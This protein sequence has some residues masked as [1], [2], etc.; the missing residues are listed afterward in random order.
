MKSYALMLERYDKAMRVMWGL[1]DPPIG[2]ANRLTVYIV[3]NIDVVRRLLGSSGRAAGFYTGRAEG[4]VAVVPLRTGDGGRFGLDPDTV[5]FHEYAH[6]LMMLNYPLAFPAWYA[7][8]FAEFNSTAKFESDGSVGLGL[9][10][11]HRAE[12]LYRDNPLTIEMMLSGKTDKFTPDQTEALYSRGWLLTHYLSFDSERK[13]QV[14][15][16]LAGLNS[17]RSGVEAAKAAFGDLG[18]LERELRRYARSPSLPYLKIGPEKLAA[19]SIAVRRLSVGESTIID[20]KMRSKVGVTPA[21]AK[22]LVAPMRRAAAPF[23]DDPVVQ[24]ALAEAEYDADNHV[25]AEAAAD[26]AL[27]VD[28]ANVEALLYKGRAR[29]ALAKKAGAKDAETWKEVRRWFIAANRADPNDPEPLMLFYRSYA[30]QEQ[31]PT[32]NAVAALIQAFQLAPHDKGLRATVAHRYLREGNAAQAMFALRPLAY[33]PHGGAGAERM[34]EV[35]DKI[36]EGGVEAA[37]AAWDSKDA[38]PEAG[39]T[40]GE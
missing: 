6:H 11:M 32:A 13:G 20:F 17:G 35:M 21:Q 28:P 26:R 34:A 2:P 27:A 7:E 12:S 16:Y 9:A 18:K 40:K 31:A 39:A 4:S 5:L 33:S 30:A 38:E 24:V 22:D 1:Q 19:S 14:Q 36:A 25:E 10:A 8:G 23:A 37:L 15:A 29:M 3:R